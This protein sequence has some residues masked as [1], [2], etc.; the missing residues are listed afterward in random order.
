MWLELTFYYEKFQAYRKGERIA[1]M[2][3][4]TPYIDSI[5][6]LRHL[7]HLVVCVFSSEH[8]KQVANIMTFYCQT[9]QHASFKV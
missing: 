6:V 8:F 3:T 7:I 9:L 1:V 5:I 4:L 2:D